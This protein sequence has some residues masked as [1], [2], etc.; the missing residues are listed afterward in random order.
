M[1]GESQP[2]ELVPAVSLNKSGS[3]AK[4]RPRL[5]HYKADRALSRL[6][7]WS[8][9]TYRALLCTEYPMATDEEEE[10]MAADAWEWS[11]EMLNVQCTLDGDY[12]NVVCL[13][14]SLPLMVLFDFSLSDPTIYI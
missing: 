4:E 8:I 9:M 5:H 13:P 6:L 10:S 14:V 1:Q 3:R 2:P 11:C 7:K 12:E